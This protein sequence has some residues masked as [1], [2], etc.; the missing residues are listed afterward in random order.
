MFFLKYLSR[1]YLS[2][3]LGKWKTIARLNAGSP[4]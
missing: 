4:L 1:M 2:G 3:A